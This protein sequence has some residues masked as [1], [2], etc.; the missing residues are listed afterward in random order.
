VSDQAANVLEAALQLPTD[1]RA[2]LASELLR[3]LDA[4]EATLPQAEV[5]RRWTAELVRRAERAG[6]GE[7]TGRDAAG[8]LSAIEA[9]LRAR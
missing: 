4:D 5:D 9:K 2:D 3:S 8:V 7:S 1:Q 6:R